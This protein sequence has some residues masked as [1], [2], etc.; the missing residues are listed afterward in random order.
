[1]VNFIVEV[2][3]STATAFGPILSRAARWPSRVHAAGTI[4]GGEGSDNSGVRVTVPVCVAAEVHTGQSATVN[5]QK[6]LVRAHVIRVNDSSTDQSR[7]VDLGLDSA[8]PAGIGADHSVDATIRFGELNN[9]LWI[10][11][12]A[13]G[14]LRHAQHL[15]ETAERPPS[16]GTSSNLCSR[17]RLTFNRFTHFSIDFTCGRCEPNRK[18][19][20][21]EC[22]RHLHQLCRRS[23]SNNAPLLQ[24]YLFQVYQHS[25]RTPG[26]IA[27]CAGLQLSEPSL[28][29]RSPCTGPRFRI[30]HD[31]GIF[32]VAI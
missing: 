11:R 32:A 12:P 25:P 19:S 1:M 15:R 9:V 30:S 3:Q 16:C 29:K 24:R 28:W 7:S 13:H 6:R 22:N 5:T 2:P 23:E 14:A 26:L 17:G 18:K 27:A 31:H 10:Y 8:L 21:F 20:K 4:V